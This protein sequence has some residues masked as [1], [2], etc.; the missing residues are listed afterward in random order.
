MTARTLLSRQVEESQRIARETRNRERQREQEM[1]NE[2]AKDS[3]LFAEK[4]ARLKAIRMAK[5][6]GDRDEALQ[7]AAAKLTMPRKR[8]AGIK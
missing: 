2:K 4:T 3:A 8:A 7:A 5:E 6:A 1:L